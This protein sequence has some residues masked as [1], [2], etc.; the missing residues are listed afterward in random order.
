LLLVTLI[1]KK[2]GER[3]REKKRGLNL[4]TLPFDICI[5]GR[6]RHWRT[7]LIS[8]YACTQ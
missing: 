3:E 1:L 7:I 4:N 5:G 8:F 6:Q 2:R